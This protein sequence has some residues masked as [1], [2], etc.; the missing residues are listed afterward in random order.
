MKTGNPFQAAL[1]TSRAAVFI[2]AFV[3]SLAVPPAGGQEAVPAGPRPP[4]FPNA[5]GIDV[6][7]DAFQRAQPA[8]AAVQ[9]LIQDDREGRSVV[10]CGER[11]YASVWAATDR[12]LAGEAEL[13]KGVRVLEDADAWAALATARRSGEPA[14]LLAACR[15]Y[16][17]AAATHAALCECG[18]ELVREGRPGLAL[19][20]FQD[21]RRRAGSVEL[22]GRAQVG[23]WTAEA[24]LAR[25]PVEIE[26]A[27]RGVDATAFYP[28]MGRPAAA[29]TI[30]ERLVAGWK[31]PPAPADPA[32][33]GVLP[34][35]LPDRAFWILQFD[36]RLDAPGRSQF[37]PQEVQPLAAGEGVL[38]AGPNL[39]AWYDR[40]TLDKPRWTHTV[41]T[42]LSGWLWARLAPG[43][44]RPT[45]LEGTIYTRWG[46][47]Q[48]AQRRDDEGNQRP[49]HLNDIAAFDCAT[50]RLLW[51]TSGD[52]AWQGLCPA[53]DPAYADGRLYVL[54]LE[55]GRAYCQVVLAALDARSGDVLW[56]RDLAAGHTDIEEPDGPH[57]RR[58]PRPRGKPQ[59][60]NNID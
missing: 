37:L 17:W 48:S 34:L 56:K 58:R 35:Q 28:W 13:L 45:I 57:Q 53:G 36:S 2:A 18:E 23:V 21:V 41:T 55:K 44:F 50:G 46:I 3:F 52:P 60:D 25:S 11:Q 5:F 33:V 6:K 12:R 47:E 39:L 14:R 10:A 16:P 51:S 59:Y 29:K 20:C 22:L 19:R 27:F 26:Q 7:W 42:P 54:A 1:C 4:S 31:P 8:P 40:E 24:H 15:R 9:A 30:C 32:S 49:N 43:P 38:V